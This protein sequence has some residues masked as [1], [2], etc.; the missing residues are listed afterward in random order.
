MNEVSLYSA[1]YGGVGVGGGGTGGFGAGSSGTGGVG[2]AGG[3]GGVA[4]SAGRDLFNND[5]IKRRLTPPAIKDII[6]ELVRRGNAEWESPSKE[7][8]LILWRK[9]EEWG[10]LVYQWAFDRGHTNSV[11][12]L[13]EILHGEDTEDQDFHDLDERIMKKALESLAKSG[14]AQLFT[15][16]SDSDL[17]VKFF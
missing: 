13:Y 17:G 8:C 14:K 7:R 10:A 1:A 11:C 15:G 6:D 2:R 9:P 12:T 3:V 5:K 16:S 4:G